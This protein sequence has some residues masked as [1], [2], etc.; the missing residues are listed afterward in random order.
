MPVRGVKMSENKIT[1]SGLKALQGWRDISTCSQAPVTLLLYLS[2]YLRLKL[3][4]SEPQRP[5]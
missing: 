3:H 2:K 1:P 5:C 4:P